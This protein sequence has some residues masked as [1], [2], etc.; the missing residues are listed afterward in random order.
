MTPHALNWSSKEAASHILSAISSGSWIAV[1]DACVA[2]DARASIAWGIFSPSGILATCGARILPSGVSS[3]DAEALACSSAAAELSRMRAGPS[4]SVSDC[5]PAV[6]MLGREAAATSPRSQEALAA[7][8]ESTRGEA[9]SVL[10]VPR[11]LA[12]PAND[13][14]RKILG[15]PPE[16]RARRPWRGWLPALLKLSCQ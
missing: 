10:W 11:S 14:A 13:A 9:R 1:S 3:T 2:A 6:Q 12:A 15:L 8:E 4:I 7:W 16:T 5:L